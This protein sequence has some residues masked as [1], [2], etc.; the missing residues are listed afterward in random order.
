[1]PI[2]LSVESRTRRGRFILSAIV[3]VLLLGAFTMVYPFAV[4]LSGALRSEMDE[5]DLDLIPAF[6]IDRDA[7][8]RKF[9]ETKYNNDVTLLNGAHR[10]LNFSF[11]EAAVPARIVQRRIDDLLAFLDE[12]RP[13]RHWQLLGGMAGAGNSKLAAENLR[14]FRD[15]LIRRF[16]GD[17]GAFARDTGAPVDNWESLVGPVVRWLNPQFDFSDDA[18]YAA[19]FDLL[20]RQPW[21]RRQLVSLTQHFLETMVFPQHGRVSTDS[22]NAAH[23]RKLRSFVEFSLPQTVPPEDQPAERR[24]WIDFAR[25]ELNCSFVLLDESAQDAWR[26]FLRQRYGTIDALNRAWLA[27]PS[28]SAAGDALPAAS[29]ENIRLPRGQWL[30]GAQRVDYAEF[31]HAQDP[32]LYRLVGP[33]FAW[34][35]WLEARYGTVQA[36]N[37]AHQTQ[38]AS[39]DEA[40]M[41]IDELEYAHV[42]QSPHALRWTY[43]TRNFRVVFRELL[44]RGRAMLNTAILCIGTVVLTLLVNPL[45]AYAMSRFRLRGTY[46]VLLMMMVTMAFPPM[47]TAIPTFIMLRELELLNTFAAL[48]L[49]FVANG[50]QVFLLKGFF[51]SLPRELY[52]SA[53]IDGASEARIFF[54]ITMA[55]SKPILA[56]V[57]LGAFTQAYTMF[58]FPLIV[59]PRTDMWTINVWL[60]QWQAAASTCGVFAALL[61]ASIPTLLVFILAQNYIIRGIVVPVEK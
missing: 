11:R 36:L 2:V 41:P 20:E 40:R 8:Y 10:R 28:D 55:L 32:S 5:S 14:R 37:A 52:E 25:N 19:W 12:T 1:M 3:A 23:A 4:M 33:E 57:A 45:A 61:I 30:R 59:C 54:Q 48:I 58:L 27:R 29:F 39:F 35:K 17:L 43:A 46:K 6:L 50:Y 18:I 16:N 7:L 26:A 53:T 56:V 9:L 38:L 21:A 22:Y 34:R 15:A 24:Q 42:L 31:L 44:L 47:V 60:F 13:P 49:P 51:D